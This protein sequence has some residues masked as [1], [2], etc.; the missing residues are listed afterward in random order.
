MEPVSEFHRA[1]A[2]WRKLPIYIGQMPYGSQFPFTKGICPMQIRICRTQNS[3]CTRQE[4][5]GPASQIRDQLPDYRPVAAVGWLWWWARWQIRQAHVYLHFTTPCKLIAHIRKH[6]K[7]HQ[8][9]KLTG[10]RW[11]V[12]KSQPPVF[13]SKTKLTARIRFAITITFSIVL[14]YFFGCKVRFLSCT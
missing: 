8:T 10:A 14:W 11:Y 12:R 1:I 6:N 13:K 3:T 9:K 4:L 2:L 7:R 5:L